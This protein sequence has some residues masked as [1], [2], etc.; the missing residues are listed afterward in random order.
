MKATG[1]VRRIDELGRIVIPKEIRK[2][3]TIKPCENLEIFTLDNETI[4]LKKYSTLSRFSEIGNILINTL[5]QIIN[6]EV[7]L[8]DTS[9]IINYRGKRKDL[10][11]N[12]KISDDINKLLDERTR[13]IE[14]KQ[15]DIIITDS[16]VNTSY[17]IE[18]LIINGDLIG[19][20]II[21]SDTKFDQKDIEL[22]S[23]T[24]KI[25]NNYIEQ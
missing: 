19:G 25:L 5:Y 11:L 21:L 7:L 16:V 15:L 13:I 23:Y 10:F 6:K 4:A 17:M 1:V 24:I 12:K 18:P 3:M 2:N 8:I 14:N 9:N 22:T 20:I